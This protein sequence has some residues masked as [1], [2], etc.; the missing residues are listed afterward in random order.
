MKLGTIVEQLMLRDHFRLEDAGE[1]SVEFRIRM[2]DKIN[3][4]FL[5]PLYDGVSPDEIANALIDL[6]TRIREHYN[7]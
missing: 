2:T 6:G 5:C 4:N 7:K 3:F 1:K